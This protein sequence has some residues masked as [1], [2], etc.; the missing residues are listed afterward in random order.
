MPEQ[1][2]LIVVT[3]NPGP[4]GGLKRTGLWLSELTHFYDEME[5]RGFA[6]DFVSPQGGAVPLD[7]QSLLPLPLMADKSTR[8][9]RGDT[10][11]MDRLQSTLKPSEVE[12]GDYA[13]IYFTGGHG[14]MWD[15]PEN[16]ELQR[17]AASIYEQGGAVSAVCHGVCGLVNVEL[18]DGKKLVDGKRVTGFSNLEE[19]LALKSGIVPFKVEDGLKASGADYSRATLPLQGHVVADGR[20]VTGQNPGS[21]RA[22]AR[23]LAGVLG[24]AAN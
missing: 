5:R 8:A 19:V 18:S 23:E 21:A 3:N 12:A 2:I 7:P 15:F 10:Q 13:A 22:V 24:A 17:L 6:M 16:A 4:G 1:K 11:F 14:T 20:L 9:R